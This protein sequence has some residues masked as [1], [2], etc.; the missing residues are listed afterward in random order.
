M[1]LPTIT[2]RDSNGELPYEDGRQHTREFAGEWSVTLSE[3]WSGKVAILGE[4]LLFLTSTDGLTWE[5][6]T[7]KSKRM[8]EKLNSTVKAP[9]GIL[10][11]VLTDSED[12]I[13]QGSESE[14][15]IW[16]TNLTESELQEI[17]EEIGRLALSTSTYL[18]SQIR[19]PIREGVGRQTF[20]GKTHIASYFESAEALIDLAETVQQNWSLIC[21]RPL[22]KIEMEVGIQRKYQTS[23]PRSLIDAKIRPA[24][25]DRLGLVRVSSWDCSENRFLCYVL[26]HFLILQGRYH[27]QLLQSLTL[28][29]EEDM[30]DR[31][32]MNEKGD[33]ENGL[34][35]FPLLAKQARK[36]REEVDEETR[37]LLKQTR[38]MANQLEEHVGWARRARS[39]PFLREIVTPEWLP[40]PSQ[41]LLG[42]PGYEAVA[43]RLYNSYQSTLDEPQ[44]ALALCKEIQLGNVRG[45]WEL[46]EIWCLL[47][48]YR[49]FV[50]KLEFQV[51]GLYLFDALSV[52]RGQLHIPRNTRFGL[53][54][55]IEGGPNLTADFYYER[56]LVVNGQS[57]KPDIFIEIGIADE[58][59]TFALDA[60]YRDY[61]M[62]K[63]T[64]IIEDVV[65]CAQNKYRIPYKLNGSF[66][67]HTDKQFD[68]W[69]EMPLTKKIQREY[70]I[71]LYKDNNRQGYVGHRQGAIRLRPGYNPDKQIR[72]LASLMFQYHGRLVGVCIHCL[73]KLDPKNGEIQMQPTN[74]EKQRHQ[75]NNP[76]DIEKLLPLGKYEGRGRPLY[77]VCG[78][79]SNFWVIQHCGN[80]KHLL[81]KAGDLCL[82]EEMPNHSWWYICPECGKQ[83]NPNYYRYG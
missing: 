9:V 76:E 19:N 75:I 7:P 29:L 48:I 42:T 35:Y 47:R 25:K 82:H 72:K 15:E 10:T 41:R 6:P 80:P 65:D 57:R 66:I 49:F 20:T 52:R 45:T 8:T 44:P 38:A 43:N 67:L 26:D 69:G 16:P 18:Q 60:K 62:Q 2:F 56:E 21:K 40:P 24:K 46:Y 17:L 81:L 68:Y 53:K 61:S 31:E 4:P 22:N 71:P 36:R 39:A 77:C 5:L 13:V 70:N 3:R 50:E 30:K 55:E 74:W 33:I 78:V 28:E 37:V 58:K 11:V 79:C 32:T 64:Q 63:E 23:S 54:R 12:Q 73:R 59:L 1:S 14:L 27:V 51:N 83:G 34:F